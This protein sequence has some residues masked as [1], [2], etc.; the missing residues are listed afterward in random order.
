MS[1]STNQDSS[2]RDSRIEKL[3]DEFVHACRLGD[4]ISRDE[5]V[6]ANPELEPELS[7]RLVFAES[8]VEAFQKAESEQTTQLPPRNVSERL[9]C[10]HCGNIVQVVDDSDEITCG[11]CGSSIDRD[12]EA[13]QVYSPSSTRIAHF[14]LIDRVGRGGFGVV[15]RA[16]DTR[17]NR[18]VAL[19]IPRRGHFGTKEEEDRFLREARSAA[20]LK[21]PNIVQVYEVGTER[22]SHYIA[23]EFID[24]RNLSDV[25][26]AQL[27]DFRRTATLLAKIA[28]A[29][30]YAHN[31]GVIHRDVKPA[32][33]LVD[34]NDEPYLADFG[35]ARNDEP[36]ITVTRDGE[37]LGTPAYMSPEQAAA[38]H[39]RLD[40]R[41]D[42][43]S[44]GVTLF[45]M[46]SGELPFRGSRRML[47]S[48]V[49]NDDPP[50]VR[51]LNESAPRDLETIALRAME[52]APEKRY[53]T[54]SE[55]GQEL[56]RWLAGDPILAR[57]ISS[58]ERAWR[59]CRKRPL[60]ASL[61][62]TIALLLCSIGIGGVVWGVREARLKEV[63]QASDIESRERLSSALADSAA[64]KLNDDDSFGSLPYAVEALGVRQTLDSNAEHLMRIQLESTLAN[65]PRL[66]HLEEIGESVGY[67]ARRPDGQG[68]AVASGKTVRRYDMN[69]RRLQPDLRSQH[70]AAIVAFSDDSERVLAFEKDYND[71]GGATVWTTADGRRTASITHPGL[72]DAVLNPEGTLVATGGGVTEAETRVWSVVDGGLQSTFRQGGD[73]VSDV[74]FSPHGKNLVASAVEPLPGV[75]RY[76]LSRWTLA[77]GE[78][79]KLPIVES[80]YIKPMFLKDGRLLTVAESGLM[81]RY[82][83]G[84]EIDESFRLQVGP[85][86]SMVRLDN[87][88]IL[89][90]ANGAVR[91]WDLTVPRL[92]LGPI[93]HGGPIYSDAVSPD[94]TMFATAGEHDRVNVFR[95][96]TG[97]RVGPAIGHGATVRS[98]EFLSNT[99]L[100]TGTTSGVLKIWDLSGITRG[101]TL[102]R[103]SGGLSN[104]QFSPDSKRVSTTSYIQS[105]QATLWNRATGEQI[106]QVEHGSPALVSAFSL[107]GQT[108]VSG[109]SKGGLLVRSGLGG[110]EQ[111]ESLEAAGS[112]QKIRFSPTDTDVFATTN[113]T[114]EIRIWRRGDA[115]SIRLFEHEKMVRGLQFD[116]TGQFLASASDDQTARVWNLKSGNQ[117]GRT[118]RDS[119]KIWWCRFS[120]DGK[121]LATSGD[122]GDIIFWNWRTGEAVSRFSL[123]RPQ[124]TFDFSPDG[125]EMCSISGSGL[126]RIWDIQDDSEPRWSFSHPLIRTADWHPTLPLVVAAG[127]RK[128]ELGRP[129][130]RIWDTS[131]GLP[132]S[133]KLPH[134]GSARAH[135]SPD[136]T[137]ILS[138]SS[139]TT[140]RIWSIEPTQ[141]DLET[142]RSLSVVLS[143][144][145][146]KERRLVP[147]SAAVQAR[148]FEELRKRIPDEFTPSE[149]ERQHFDSLH[150]LRNQ[151]E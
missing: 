145:V 49:L 56:Q 70:I 149:K 8:L 113:D 50:L 122:S 3:V 37:V 129:Y 42:I 12:E 27:L 2:E 121:L 92:R 5:I 117:E 39:S 52:K 65:S 115:N 29:L 74:T 24:G 116:P 34:A 133:P 44:L 118:L 124:R 150:A 61:L 10:P 85:T 66:L 146:M 101:S 23:T 131:S 26:K 16:K 82:D 148:T 36:A 72:W 15:Y 95:M 19:K 64:E 11:G 46:L 111:P 97:E 22:G 132:L 93:S 112:V 33:I 87:N 119:A 109:D 108:L 75:S 89:T 126:V 102:L 140:A 103:H 114:G 38:E 68:F 147:V 41:S 17:L 83:A 30:D 143:G 151:D 43:Y 6:A 123:S 48:K 105:G 110:A 54:A 35:L 84:G 9:R 14:D 78:E 58:L 13:T 20:S 53:Q 67:I 81:R 71:Q 139:D 107:D 51:S 28:V 31:H 125:T 86:G 141:Y 120:P 137:A 32:N 106:G 88:D 69:W 57:P 62:A 79:T 91:I 60:I 21:H 100:A 104:S 136:G 59:W 94:G 144:S 40:R 127:D 55:F 142:L 25:V 96:A 45:R 98:I 135:F 130:A 134:A 99:I 128:G 77:T 47:L 73:S 4:L 1:E 138:H 18:D 76:F 7:R 80:E 63:A 90:R